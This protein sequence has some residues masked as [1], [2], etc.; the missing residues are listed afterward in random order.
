MLEEIAAEFTKGRRLFIGT[1]N[2]DAKRPVIWNIGAIAASEHPD[3][4]R[5]V[6]SVILASASIPGIFPPVY[7]EA[8]ADGRRYDEMHVDGGAASQVFLYPGKFDYAYVQKKLGTSFKGS[9]FIIRN[10][11]LQMKWKKVKPK[12]GSIATESIS[13]LIMTQG[14]GDIYRIYFGTQRDG[15][16]YNLA[17]IP[18]SFKMEPEEPFDQ[19]YMTKLFELGY[20]LAINGYPW[21]NSPP[22]FF[23]I[24]NK[25][26]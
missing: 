15:I 3:A 8:E 10:S 20:N 17:Y 25:N 1:T 4:L 18:E 24:S 16:D 26:N 12:I 22:G 14:L 5:L 19:E 7:I 9:A 21:E 23:S 2:L 13:T 11:Q 6:H